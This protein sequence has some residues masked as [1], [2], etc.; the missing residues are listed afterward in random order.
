MPSIYANYSKYQYGIDACSHIATHFD[1]LEKAA[2]ISYRIIDIAALLI[3]GISPSFKMLSS[4]IK[5]TILIIE[6][7]RFFPISFPL[8]F[9]N[10]TGKRFF[11]IKTKIQVAERVAL[12]AHLVFKLAYGLDR[13]KLITLGII[14]TYAIGYI[15]LFRWLAEGLILS[16]NVFGAL[17]GALA[18]S[19]AVKKLESCQGKIDKWKMRHQIQSQDKKNKLRKWEDIQRVL[20]FDR[21]KASL[22]LIATVSKIILITVAVSLA[23]IN[24]VT[25]S[26][27]LT[28]L[29][30]G[31]ISDLLGLARIFYNEFR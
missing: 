26:G 8:F 24:L 30:L 17:D 14:G 29:S 12:A 7:T 13:V 1:S 23:A 5:D 28:V 10:E 4:Q 21:N 22:Q 6:T 25:F 27:Q 3:V 31:I 9:P 18:L 19:R 11:Q 20:C 16:Y 15:P 2:K